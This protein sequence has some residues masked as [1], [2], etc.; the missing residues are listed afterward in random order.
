MKLFAVC[1]PG[2]EPVLMQELHR[3][4][5]LPGEGGGSPPGPEI[6]RGTPSREGGIEFS[7]DREIVYR[8]NLHLRTATRVLLRLGEFHAVSFPEFRRKAGLLPWESYLAAQRPI[9]FRVSCHK[10]RLYH[11]GAVAE[12]LAGAIADRLGRSPVVQPFRDSHDPHPPQLIIARLVRDHCTISLDTSGTALFRRGY[13]QATAKAPLRETLA[14]AL[15]MLS[16]WDRRSPL[17]D[18]FCGSGTIVIEAALL[19]RNR[20]PGL[21]RRFAFMDWPDFEASL[22]H[23]LVDEAR[24]QEI[25]EAPPIL[26]SDKHPGALRAARANAD[27]AGVGE[28]IEFARRPV[29]AV[30]PPP[31]PGWVVS[32]LPYGI[33]T[34]SDADLRQV[35]VQFG[36]VLRERF[37]GWRVTVLAGKRHLLRCAGAPLQEHGWINNGGVRVLLAQGT[38]PR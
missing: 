20:A 19:A 33:R 24:K 6:E 3:L 22:W 34:R 30:Q 26:A 38:V 13:R 8:C 37:P 29:S 10:S 2:L 17:M 14:A 21:S 28:D 27:R 36:R 11:S 16:G 32:N 12:R 7:G 25:P 35:Y 15:L 4:G 31:E 23:R 5:I 9:A 1:A 18:P